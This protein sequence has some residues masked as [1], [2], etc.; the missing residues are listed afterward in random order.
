MTELLADLVWWQWPLLVLGVYV[1]LL[2]LVHGLFDAAS[3]GWHAGKPDAGS[4]HLCPCGVGH[5]GDGHV[6]SVFST[7]ATIHPIRREDD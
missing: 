5:K 3:T 4:N 2:L 6:C 7:P 1:A